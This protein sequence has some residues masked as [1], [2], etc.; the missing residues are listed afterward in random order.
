MGE[1]MEQ[2]F[3]Y[4]VKPSAVQVRINKENSNIGQFIV[5]PLP[6]GYAITLGNAMRRV[7][8]SSIAG[9]AVTGLK[10]EGIL[11]EFSTLPGV[12]EDVLNII[13]NLK[14]VCFKPLIDTFTEDKA[15]I[16]KKGEGELKAGDIVTSSDV[17]VVNK[18]SHIA[19]L[20]EG[21]E[22]RMKLLLEKGVGYKP[23]KEDTEEA[24]LISVD[25]MF[26]Q[27]R[28]VT[29]RAEKSTC[30]G[31]YDYD[32]LTL[33]VETNGAL[34][35]K[36]AVSEASYILKNY[37]GFFTQFA[38]AVESSLEEKVEKE[39]KINEGLLKTVDELELSARAANCLKAQNIERIW[40]LVQ[41]TENGL[42]NTR[43]FGK[44]SLK[45]IKDALNQLGLSLNMKIDEDTLLRIKE[46]EVERREKECVTNTV[47]GNWE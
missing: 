22:V 34:T 12:K 20:M 24:G 35:P 31:F 44:Q 43:N 30:R 28:R 45:E 11:H 23:A 39:K 25:A 6:K 8:L 19:F 27:V 41:K 17:E 47:I 18:D 38:L 10:I 33:E 42:L 3:D 7:L 2:I 14:Q 21:S 16:G 36:D 37:V 13:L 40:E 26:S 5:Q 9:V 46:L 15:F 4:L 1:R 29:Y 32:K